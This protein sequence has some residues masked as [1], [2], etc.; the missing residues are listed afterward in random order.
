[1]HDCSGRGICANG[2]CACDFGWRGGDC[3]VVSCP[4]GCSS[5]GT[6]TSDHAVPTCICHDLF[7]GSDCGIPL[8]PTL[9]KDPYVPCSGHGACTQNGTCICYNNYDGDFCGDL[10]DCSGR[11]L[12]KCGFCNCEAGFS[13]ANCEIDACADSRILDGDKPKDMKLSKV[14]SGKGVCTTAKGCVCDSGAG[15]NCSLVAKCPGNCNGR[16][17]CKGQNGLANDLGTCVCDHYTITDSPF[18]TPKFDGVSCQNLLCPGVRM[19]G[20]ATVVCSG[21][22]TCNRVSSTAQCDCFNVEGEGLYR[23]EDCGVPPR[24]FVSNFEPKVGPLEGGTIIIIS[25]PGLERLLAAQQRNGQDM[26][27]DFQTNETTPVEVGP[28]FDTVKC[29]S[30][31]VATSR[32][33]DLKFVNNKGIELISGG[34][35][36]AQFEYFVQTTVIR[37]FPSYAPLRPDGDNGQNTPDLKRSNTVTVTGD[38]FPPN[39]KYVCRFGDCDAHVGKTRRLDRANLE[40]EM[41]PLQN[42]DVYAVAVTSNAQQYSSMSTKS[43]SLFTVYGIT[44]ISPKCASEQGSAKLTV[45]GKHLVDES[46]LS[47]IEER[48]FCR[49]GTVTQVG[50]TKPSGVSPGEPRFFRFAFH[51]KATISKTFPGALECRVPDSTVET[52][53][54]AI[55][56]DAEEVST[57]QGDSYW[58]GQWDSNP[59][60]TYSTYYPP[61]ILA[62]TEGRLGAWRYRMVPTLGGVAGGTRVT[63]GGL[64]FDFTKYHPDSEKGMQCKSNT[65]GERVV[66]SRPKCNAAPVPLCTF[67]MSSTSEVEFIDESHVVCVSPVLQQKIDSPVIVNVEL[68]MDGQTFTNAGLA[69]QYN[70]RATVSKI[71]PTAGVLSGGTPIIVSG[72]GFVDS[73]DKKERPGSLNVL[74]CV[75]VSTADAKKNIHYASNIP[76]HKSSAVRFSCC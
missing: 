22:G 76:E 56:L 36:S 67:G 13:G 62:G 46:D 7:T 59:V 39:G 18:T 6:C 57:V 49:F 51:S 27:C 74:I 58:S 73:G 40:C 37:V 25:G 43:N 35:I 31:P 32:I 29:V 52:S 3:S 20:T 5:H 68:A 70:P 33:V 50:S 66:C 26:R 24:Y 48:F 60:V 47:R 69:F 8:C 9:R 44:D 21:K 10:I 71:A 4:N 1:M 54:F 28:G 12:R 64:R 63:I 75:F 72:A 30:P 17:T 55:T 16:G 11:G 42:A 38:Y 19:M 65:P 53:F 41:P 14:C 15:K 2:T 45:F 34:K 61:Q 23:G